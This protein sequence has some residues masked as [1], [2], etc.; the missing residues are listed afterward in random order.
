VN[1]NVA[2]QLQGA[3]V[4]PAG[5]VLPRRLRHDMILFSRYEKYDT[6]HK[7]PQGF[8]PLPQFNRSSWVVGAT[9]KPN[10]DIAVKFDYDFNRNAS[11]VVRAADSFNAGIG[12]W[13]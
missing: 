2:A 10:A 9:Y 5:H 3:Y 7:M 13:F 12:W 6:Q 8:V 4:E 11:S 1:P